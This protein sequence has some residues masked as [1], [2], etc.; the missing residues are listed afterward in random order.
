MVAF[1]DPFFRFDLLD[2]TF[3]VT[4]DKTQYVSTV[5]CRKFHMLLHKYLRRSVI[6]IASFRP[7]SSILPIDVWKV[8]VSDQ[9]I[10]AFQ[11]FDPAAQIL[12]V[13][14]FFELG[15]LYMT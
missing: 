8:H 3:A 14:F 12:V 15:D 11:I 7:R 2:H 1:P 6:K 5:M 13:S 4:Q 10:R 9:Y